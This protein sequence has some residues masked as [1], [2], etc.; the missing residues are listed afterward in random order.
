MEI[1]MNPLQKQMLDDVFDA[2][3]MLTDAAYISLMHV[4]GGFTRYSASAVEMLG[5]PGEYIPNGALDWNDY[6]HPE[7]RARYM[8]V[9]FPLIEGKTQTYDIT[10]RV[11]LKSGEYGN[12]RA[13]GAVL[14]GEQG[15]PS[16]IGGATFNEGIANNVDPVTVLPNREAYRE[17]L[18][19]LISQGK[20]TVSLMVGTGKFGELNQLHGYSYGNRI[21][22]EMAWMI[23][24][25]VGD[26]GEVFRMDGAVFIVLSQVLNR[27]EMAALYDVISYRMQRGIQVN[28]IRNNLS[29]DGGM[30]ANYDA[31]VDALV[32]DTCLHYAYEES[33][34]HRHGELVDFNGSIHDEGRKRLEMLSD[35]RDSVTE[36]CKGFYM[37][38]IPVINA[39]TEEPNGAEGVLCWHDEVYGRVEG[40]KFL[41]VLENDFIFEELGDF[42][43]LT[44]L[45]DGVKFLEKNPNFLLCL[46]VYRIQLEAGYFVETL[47]EYLDKTGFPP[48]LLSLKLHSDCR[49]VSGDI[50]EDIIAKLHERKIVVIIDGFG[51]GTN[52]IIFLKNTPVDAVCIDGRFTEGIDERKRDLDIL[53]NLTKMA[54]T[55]VPHVNIT[56]VATTQIRDLVRKL[57][58]TTMQGEY[59][60]GAV[61]FEKMVEKYYEA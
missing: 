8:E 54:R 35:I 24:D 12:F 61:T 33:K 11:R 50:L 2:F 52:S 48:H 28:G 44:G 7:D 58:I 26:R 21:L 46:N 51:S 36:D 10:Y 13:V 25:L 41:P 19:E 39:Q 31:N 55:C 17:R 14:R 1:N 45:E 57:P 56:G 5:L 27:G 47:T 30:I 53:E 37:E 38:Y 23:Q 20:E 40:T 6:L 3:S 32:I 15:K 42:M 22:Q 18:A 49:F 34:I 60:S 29:T 16:L 9:M 43:L 59:Y 4:D